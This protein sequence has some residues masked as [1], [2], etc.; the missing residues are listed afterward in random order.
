[1][2][3][4]DSFLIN[5][6][7]LMG[8]SVIAQILGIIAAPIITRIYGPASYGIS[9]L[10]A[11][12]TSIIGVVACLR[13]EMSIMLPEKDEDAASMLVT[14]FLFVFITTLLVS[15][16]V[17]FLGEQVTYLLKAPELADYL[18]L[19]PAMVFFSGIFLALNYWNSRTKEFGRLSI[20]RVIASIATVS[21]QLG[22]GFCGHATAGG[23][24]SGQVIGKIISSSLLGGLI[25][26]ND[27]YTIKKGL[28]K[29]KIWQGIRRYK[30]FPLFDTWS[31][32]LNMV[33]IQIPSFL[34]SFFFSP[35]IVGYY[36]LSVNLL[37]MPAN[38][39]G[40]AFAQ[41]FYQKAAEANH[42]NTL[43]IVTEKVFTSLVSLG[44][45]P[46]LLLAVAGKDIVTFFFGA[47]W[48][49]AGV[50]AQILSIWIFSQFLYSPISTV[51][52]VLEKQKDFL[53]FNIVLFVIRITSIT[54]G[55]LLQN[56]RLSLI[57]LSIG[58]SLYYLSILNWVLTNSGVNKT[59]CYKAILQ[60]LI[61]CIPMLV[62]VFIAKY[63]IIMK[64]VYLIII[65][66][67]FAIPYYLTVL[68]K[69][70]QV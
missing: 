16:C 33:S 51:F 52:C 21:T 66:C 47:A 42:K 34:L 8:G 57:F 15:L 3:K 67:F 9:T 60:L 2:S 10:F 37:S 68:P 39:V 24:I 17:F 22:M 53:R 12:I 45:F 7:K 49:E 55:G 35:T 31:A 41:V 54:I 32:L 29:H 36:A 65:A 28:R 63:L 20:T 46:I 25:W 38:L 27:H 13:Y 30:K 43:D 44:L 48:L 58:S 69:I 61:H 59:R 23:L 50:Y 6:I 5:V 18:W 40:S 11:S 70:K 64:S 26:R 19:T 56:A 4:S 62:F 14:S 1:M